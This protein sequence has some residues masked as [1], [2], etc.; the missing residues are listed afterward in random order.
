MK[1]L[2]TLAFVLATTLL[3]AQ[4]ENDK[5]VFLDS[6]FKETTEGNHK[7]LRIIKDFNLE[8]EKYKFY[9][10][11]NTGELYREGYSN[12]S[13]YISFEGE[14]KEYFKNGKLKKTYNTINSKNSGPISEWYENGFI[15]I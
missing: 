2:L 11:F 7:Y 4:S 8:Q 12:G 5:K 10:Y 6:L 3:F 14:V 9:E 13:Y 1:K 15:K